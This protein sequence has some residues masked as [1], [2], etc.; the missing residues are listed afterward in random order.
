M[1]NGEPPEYYARFGISKDEA[2]GVREWI[3]KGSLIPKPTKA[4]ISA[5]TLLAVQNELDHQD[6]VWGKDKQQSF[7]GYLLILYN[8]L[9]QAQEGW[10][11]SVQSGRKS[12]LAEI[13]QVAAVALRCIEECCIE[14]YGAEGCT[15]AT[16]DKP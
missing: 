13:V 9:A 5:E 12:P 10:M 6:E 16:W 2:K 3:E 1:A 7:P 14:E 8:Q 4:R 11:K 15:T